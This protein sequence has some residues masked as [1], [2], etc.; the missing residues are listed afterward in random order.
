MNNFSIGQR[1]AILMMAGG[2]LLLSIAFIGWK[3]ERAAVAALQSVYDDRTVPLKDLSKIA[4]LLSD[5]TLDLVISLQ[6][7]PRSPLVAA[8]NHPVDM[9]VDNFAKRRGEITVLWDKY[10]AT[11][12]TPEETRLA[13]DFAEKRKAW[14]ATAAALLDRIKNGDYSP[15]LMREVLKG[16]NGE[17]RAARDALD[18][19]MQLQASVAQEAYLEAQATHQTG[20]LLFTLIIVGGMSA[21]GFF[22]WYL[23]RSITAPI[24]AS[25]RIAESIAAGDLTQAVP[26]GGR[27]EAG[28]LLTAFATMQQGLRSMV[29]GAQQ[30]AQALSRAAGELAAATQQSAQASAEQSEAAASMAAGVEEMSVSIDQVRDHARDARGVASGAGDESRAGAQVVHSSADEMRHVAEAVNSAAGTIRELENYS[31]EISAIINVIREVAD[32]TN[33]LALNAAIEA[34]RAGEQGRGFAVVADEVR[35]LAERTSESTHTIAS[36]IEKVQ[37][38]AR[39]AAHEMEGGVARVEGGVKLAHQAADS[40][41]GIQESAERVVA[42]VRDIGS[43]LDEQSAAAQDIARGVER[44]ASMSEENSASVRQTSA[45]TEKLRELATE[46]E[47]SVVRFRI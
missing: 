1:I 8:H 17:G 3:N 23:A 34:A 13:A 11:Y 22:S 47:G 19:L 18:A 44:I 33:L 12:L 4:D 37:A 16:L 28:R 9:H 26:P 20:M 24:G 30:S 45:A 5:N 32:Q 36:V 7:D 25:V 2:V 46:L 40:I 38:G 14:V 15:D 21:A 41:N 31:N 43:A 27:D 42:A 10:M 35:K 29:G 6:H 39:R